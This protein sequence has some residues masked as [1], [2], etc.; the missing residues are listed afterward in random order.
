VKKNLF[1]AHLISSTADIR[2]MNI[3]TQS[4]RGILMITLFL[5]ALSPL[6]VSAESPPVRPGA[7]PATPTAPSTGTPAQKTAAPTSGAPGA[8]KTAAPTP[9]QPQAPAGPEE[10][11]VQKIKEKYWT[12]GNQAEMGVVQN[13]LFTKRHK[14]EL[15]LTLGTV[16]GD[17]FLTDTPVGLSVGYHFSELFSTHL[18]FTKTFVNPSSALT[19]LQQTGTTANTNEPKFFLDGEA[20]ASLLYG[21]VSLLGQAILY[22]DAYVS[23]GL[24]YMSTES[25]GNLMVLGGV[26]QLLHVTQS[27]GINLAYKLLWYKETILGKVGGVNGNLGQNLG[28][29][30]NLSSTMVVGIS[31]LL[32]PVEPFPRDVAGAKPQ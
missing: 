19:T 2:N 10:A 9:D 13:R 15:G 28:R 27:I 16:Y 22:F 20:R 17:P 1:F 3:P 12:R 30:S 5:A 31:F 8:Q 25:G 14:M 7:S 6:S 21:K 29:H 24:G 11:D 23:A 4:L 26:G 18:Q 32:D